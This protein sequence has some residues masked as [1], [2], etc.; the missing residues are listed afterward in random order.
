M[1]ILN[2]CIPP[3]DYREWDYIIKN[4]DVSMVYPPSELHLKIDVSKLTQKDI[5][6]MKDNCNRQLI[7]I[8]PEI[9]KYNY[10]KNE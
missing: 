8:I 5:N 1:I 10:K 9:K 3:Y 6:W 2:Y 4:Y 7:E